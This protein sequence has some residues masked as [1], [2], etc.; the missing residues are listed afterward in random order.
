MP[1]PKPLSEKS[2]ERLYKESGLTGEERSFLQSFFSAC[3]SLY[4]AIPLRHVWTIYQQVKD[5]PKLRRKDILAFAS[6]AR[7]E[8]QPCLIFEANEIFDDDSHSELDRSIVSKELVGVGYG[9]TLVPMDRPRMN[10]FAPMNFQ[11]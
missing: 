5:A 1:Y 6:I 11:L 10:P 3:A 2:L 4:G 9:S 8:E 7:R